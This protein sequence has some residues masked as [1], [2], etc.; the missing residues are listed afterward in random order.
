MAK[1]LGAPIALGVV[2]IFALLLLTSGDQNEDQLKSTFS[3]EAVYFENQES[4]DEN[5]IQ[6]RFA[7]KSEKTNAVILEVL[8]MEESFQ[9]T[10]LD[11]EFVETID[12]PIP[13]K[14]GWEVHPVTLLIDHEEYGK[15]SI[16]TEIRPA[17]E[18]PA[19]IIYG[20]P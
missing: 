18:S 4:V 8:G 1:K 10:Y 3:I 12:F 20:K 6:I 2:T 13:P 17:G 16:K 9:R 7:D 19:P 5:H 11:S 15:V 14:Y